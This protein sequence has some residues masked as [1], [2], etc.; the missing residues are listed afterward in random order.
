[1]EVNVAITINAV[2]NYVNESVIP[3][4]PPLRGSNV[5][6]I[7]FRAR[8]NSIDIIG[9]LSWTGRIDQVLREDIYLLGSDSTKDE[10]LFYTACRNTGLAYE[11]LK[12]RAQRITMADFPDP[13][14]LTLREMHRLF[15]GDEAKVWESYFA[16]DF[17]EEVAPEFEAAI[18]PIA[19]TT[20]MMFRG[21]LKAMESKRAT[22]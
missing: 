3:T 22:Q 4:L 21:F 14:G 16:G 10:Y 8:P 17:D 1:V 6:F 18:G 11:R 15:G 12:R 13:F 7:P 9:G 2:N 20:A 19:R 5:E